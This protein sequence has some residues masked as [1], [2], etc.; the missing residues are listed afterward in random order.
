MALPA[1]QIN[2]TRISRALVS[3]GARIEVCVRACVIACVRVHACVIACV[4]MW[5][6]TQHCVRGRAACLYIWLCTCA[7]MR[8]QGLH[9][10]RVLHTAHAAYVHTQAFSCCLLPSTAPPGRARL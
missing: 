5:V 3:T 10:V 4:H 8:V 6:H 9:A 7:C 1:A 2:N